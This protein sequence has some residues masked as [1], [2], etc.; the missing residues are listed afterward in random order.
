[1][2]KQTVDIIETLV[3]LLT[4]DF[5]IKTV[6]PVGSNFLITTDCT[7]WLSIKDKITIAGK[8][9][10]VISFDINVSITVKPLDGGT[11][12]AP[13]TFILPAPNYIH[14]TLKM[15]Q[16]EVDAVNNKMALVPFVYLFEVIRDRKNTDAAS[17]IDRTTELRIFFLNSANTKDWLT[18]DHYLN[19]IDPMQQMVDLFIKN[20]RNNKLF[21]EELDYDCLPLINLSREGAQENSIFDCNLSGIEL[22]L[23][24]DIR[25]DLSCENKCKC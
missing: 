20:V 24:A 19:V 12:I 10:E 8:L 11:P 25:E 2:R 7:W 17:M 16:N 9:Y 4:V 18:D 14:G 21:T 22:R 1:M 5:F 3:A 23:F 6:T 13:S 15:A